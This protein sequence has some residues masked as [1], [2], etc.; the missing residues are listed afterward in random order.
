[1]NDYVI[2]EPTRPTL[3][4]KGSK[5]VFPVR[6]VYCIGRNYAEHAREMGH[7]PDRDPPFFFQKNADN[8][9]T[10]GRFKYPVMTEDVHHEVEMIVG[11][12]SGGKSISVADANNH[13]FGYGIGFDMTRRDLQQQAKNM[14]RPWEVGKAFEQSAPCG[15]LIPIEK[16]GVIDKGSIK[17][18]VNGDIRQDSDLAAMIW[19]VPEMIS[20]LSEY[21]ELA[22]GDLIMSGT[23]AGVNSVM[24][25]DKMTGFIE[26]L[27]ELTIFVD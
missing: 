22:A 26:G 5:S 3:P 1:M 15:A 27:G 8:I 9:I 2:A 10:N 6:R 7:D 19:S 21:F 17:L 24:P 4:V 25:G 14:G 13:V 20:I 18:S 11:L 12:K 23:P 16:T